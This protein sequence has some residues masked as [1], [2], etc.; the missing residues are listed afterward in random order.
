VID[1]GGQQLGI[2][3]PYKALALAR[4]RELDLVEVAPTANPPVCRILDFGKYKYE[5]SRR[6]REARK[7]QHVLV[8]KGIRLTPLTDDHDFETK[9]RQAREFIED[10][11]KVKV[12]VVF[13][14][15]LTLHQEFGHQML[16]RFADA[17]AD[18]GKSEGPAQMEGPRH[19]GIIFGKK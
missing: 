4:E 8:M 13:R 16:Q 11:A 18:V 6:E 3:E 17:I 10:G 12:T 15:R 14:G 5:I 2:M 19:L 1:T 9:V 7:K